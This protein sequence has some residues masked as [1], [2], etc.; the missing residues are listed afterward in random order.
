MKTSFVQIVKEN[1]RAFT[2][3]FPDIIELS[4]YRVAVAAVD[5]NGIILGAVSY[6]LLGFE[7]ALD[8]L[9]VEPKVRRQGIG[10]RLVEKVFNIIMST[11][12]LYP[13]SAQFEFSDENNELHTF[14]VSIK[15]MYTSYSHD[16]YYITREDIRGSQ[17]LHKSSKSDVN[18]QRFF[19]KSEAEQKKVLDMLMREESYEVADYELWKRNCVQELCKCVYVR[20]NLVDL[21][22]MQKTSDG[23][24]E[25][26]Y[27]YGKYPKG[28]FELLIE[29]VKELA[30]L[31]PN[32]SLT[33]EAM[34][35][36]SIR[37]A[38]HLFPRARRAKI[39]EAD[40]S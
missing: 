9:F 36:E 4:P 35:D 28:L 32:V 19:D 14:F 23:N 33:F 38:Q 8:W 13:L 2:S 11:E 20:N 21:I 10:T 34:N 40:Y 15:D 1:R 24:L 22:F 17:G 31:F 18:I 25:L 6:V 3:V 27:L 12:D 5:E 7:Y 39:Y 37:L 29:T 26:A 30:I 16:R